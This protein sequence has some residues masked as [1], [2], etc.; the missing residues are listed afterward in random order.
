MSVARSWIP[1]R[2]IFNIKRSHP[3]MTQTCT[4]SFRRK[5]AAKHTDDFATVAQSCSTTFAK[6]YGFYID[7]T[8][9]E[10]K[11][12]PQHSKRWWQLSNALI[13]NAVPRKGIS[14]LKSEHC[15]W[16]YDGKAK[17]NNFATTFCNKYNLPEHFADFDY[18]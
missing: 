18:H 7:K 15:C 3:W 14:P 5:T 12:M 4:D 13:H 2:T 1:Q 6:A 16:L 11:Q 10:L 17:A 9:A 8:K